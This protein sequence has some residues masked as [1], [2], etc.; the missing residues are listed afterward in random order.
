MK[1]KVLLANLALLFLHEY[2]IKFDS[3]HSTIISEIISSFMVIVHSSAE[4]IPKL[5]SN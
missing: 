2:L 5:V 1:F 4:N 3:G